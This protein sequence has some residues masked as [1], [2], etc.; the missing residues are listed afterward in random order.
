MGTIKDSNLADECKNSFTTPFNILNREVVLLRRQMKGTQVSS[1]IAW[2]G[3]IK[4]VFPCLDSV[5][6]MWRQRP[7]PR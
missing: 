1:V 2:V 5:S 3:A 4:Q 7:R 6:Y